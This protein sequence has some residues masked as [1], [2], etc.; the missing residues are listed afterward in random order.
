[1]LYDYVNV[2]EILLLLIELPII[3]VKRMTGPFRRSKHVTNS[4]IKL[5]SKIGEAHDSV[6]ITCGENTMPAYLI[7]WSMGKMYQTCIQS[8]V[9]FSMNLI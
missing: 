7:L 4:K 1:M 9:M 8:Y 2:I 6:N 5:P 3:C